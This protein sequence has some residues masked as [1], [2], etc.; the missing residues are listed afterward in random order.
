MPESKG[1]NVLEDIDASYS[2]FIKHGPGSLL[3]T[4]ACKAVHRFS[5]T[6]RY[7]ERKRIFV[8]HEDHFYFYY[9]YLHT[10]LN[11]FK[12]FWS[13]SAILLGTLARALITCSRQEWRVFAYNAGAITYCIRNR[14]KIQ[15][16]I[17]REFLDADLQMV[18]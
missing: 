7:T 5:G 13:L 4:P 2:I 10:P 6:A 18:I 12:L 3:I 16:G 14:K 1:Y 15:K 9:T 8:N 17:L 11:S